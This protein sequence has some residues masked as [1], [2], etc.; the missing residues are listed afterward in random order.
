[1][2]A[3]AASFL[4]N[5]FEDQALGQTTDSYG[6]IFNANGQQIGVKPG[7]QADLGTKGVPVTPTAPD[8]SPATS[9]MP[10]MV[11]ADPAAQTPADSTSIWSTIGNFFK[12]NAAHM[13]ASA[14][15]ALFVEDVV[16]IIV[17]LIL[18][19]GAVFSFKPARDVAIK[20]GKGV[21]EGAAA[22]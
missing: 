6:N 5:P 12:G 11:P 17:G 19:A 13:L 20:V 10:G 4:N 21:A 2:A 15:G 22:G 8:S 9:P 1:M 14:T 18:V 7:S 3:F 16:F